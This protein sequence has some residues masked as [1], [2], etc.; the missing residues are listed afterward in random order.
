MGIFR[1]C[2]NLSEAQEYVGIIAEYIDL[3]RSAYDPYIE[4]SRELEE[5]IVE[6]LKGRV[7]CI[8]EHEYE[9][10]YTVFLFQNK[11]DAVAFKLMWL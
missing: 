2:S 4:L 6:N 8:F 7:T 11:E 5:W 1:I 3:P 10:A 9:K